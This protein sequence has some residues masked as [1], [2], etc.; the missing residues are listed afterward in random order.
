MA[1]ELANG[2]LAALLRKWLPTP[3]QGFLMALGRMDDAVENPV[4]YRQ[5]F[6]VYS[7]PDQRDVVRALR[8]LQGL[9]ARHLDIVIDAPSILLR[10]GGWRLVHSPSQ[11]DDLVAAIST[12]KKIAGATDLEISRSLT[13][14]LDHGSVTRFI[15]GWLRRSRFPAP[16]DI[17]HAMISPILTADALRHC[18]IEMENCLDGEGFLLDVLCGK[19]AFYIADSPLH[20]RMVVRIAHEDVKAPWQLLGVHKKRNRMPSYE[21]SE[22]VAEQL[23]VAGIERQNLRLQREEK[24]Q[25]IERLLDPLIHDLDDM[26]ADWVP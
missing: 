25:A 1:C 20:G 6:C 3:P 12:I 7:E 11:R 26:L 10:S 19:E 16:P 8:H 21:A 13:A 22:W 15:R 23:A 14:A 2:R 17:R 9:N 5:L 18:S 4:F 24:W